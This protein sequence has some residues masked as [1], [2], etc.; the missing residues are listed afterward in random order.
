MK[1]TLSHTS[2]RLTVVLGF[3]LALLSFSNGIFAQDEVLSQDPNGPET[4]ALASKDKASKTNADPKSLTLPFFDSFTRGGTV[5]DTALWF[6]AVTTRLNRTGSLNPPDFGTLIFDGVNEL[7]QAYRLTN[8]SG[9]ADSAVSHYI[10]LGNYDASDSLYLT[11]YYQAGGRADP[12]ELTDSLIVFFRDTSKVANPWRKVWGHVGNIKTDRF[13]YARIPIRDTIFFHDTFQIKIQ[14]RASLS[15]FY[16]IWHVDYIRLAAN[17]TANDSTTRN[18]VGLQYQHRSPLGNYR[19]APTLHKPDTLDSAVVA[20]RNLNGTA[21]SNVALSTTLREAYSGFSLGSTQS[22]FTVP[23][24]ATDTV[25]ALRYSS[26]SLPK[27]SSLRLESKL[28]GQSDAVASN[29]TVSRTYRVDSLLGYDDGEYESGYGITGSRGFGVRLQLQQPDTLCAVWM[30]FMP[31][32]NVSNGRSFQFVLWK[33][34]NPDSAAYRQFVGMSVEYGPYLGYFQRYR[35]DSLLP[36]DTGKT[37]FIGL[38]QSDANS[39]NVGFDLSEPSTNDIYRDSVG[40]WRKSNLKGT[41][42]IRPEFLSGKYSRPVTARDGFTV[43]EEGI[44]VFPVPS[45]GP[46]ISFRLPKRLQALAG[47]AS[48]LDLAGRFCTTE[49]WVAGRN[50]NQMSI[51]SDLPNGV[52]LVRFTIAGEVYQ[53]KILLSR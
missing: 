1:A 28:V 50:P 26:F 49:R 19:L 12:P 6:D 20:F 21:S 47:E 36:I 9:R 38:R 31:A 30:S 32:F 51:P 35:I 52:Y 44:K 43:L 42:M 22:N 17:R 11:F 40:F 53:T 18:D 4:L 16:D 3:C 48:M 25:V 24:A 33:D 10:K 7:N 45:T 29:D 27:T 39:I 23:I 46:S 37:Y 14:N 13:F 34:P 2:L 5:P 8:V 41:L 15:G